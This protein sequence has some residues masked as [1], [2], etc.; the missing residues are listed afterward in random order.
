MANASK[1]SSNEV[2]EAEDDNSKQAPAPYALDI[3]GLW[4]GYGRRAALKDI[5]FQVDAGEVLGIIGPN[6]SGKTTLLKTILGLVRPWQGE[7]AVL[8]KPAEEQRRLMG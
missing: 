4:T 1:P 3:R 8:G 5:T 2:L 6:G 7:V